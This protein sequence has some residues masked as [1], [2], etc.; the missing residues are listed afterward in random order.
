M[1]EFL[2]ILVKYKEN[3]SEEEFLKIEQ[4][5]QDITLIDVHV[6]PCV[7][8]KVYQICSD[9][10][11]HTKKCKNYPHFI[12]KF[13]ILRGVYEMIND[14]DIPGFEIVDTIEENCE[15]YCE[16]LLNLSKSIFDGI[17][18]L[19]IKFVFINYFFKNSRIRENIRLTKEVKVFLYCAK[20]EY[21]EY[22]KLLNEIDT[23]VCI[24]KT[25]EF[26]H[27]KDCVNRELAMYIYPLL[28]EYYTDIVN[29]DFKFQKCFSEKVIVISD[30]RNLIK[31]AV[32]SQNETIIMC[33]INEFFKNRFV[34]NKFWIP[35]KWCFDKGIHF[36]KDRKFKKVIK[37]LRKL[38]EERSVYEEE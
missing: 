5:T 24:C 12:A 22:F 16:S 28:C 33:L 26:C 25:G 9:D 7:C 34:F 21:E 4:F 17:L 31:A 8:E 11:F 2:D 15:G 20:K 30:L 27:I 3:F 19:S 35:V 32:L 6:R 38:C 1:S 29:E 36:I 14:V 18:E 23:N 10:F 37:K 13:P